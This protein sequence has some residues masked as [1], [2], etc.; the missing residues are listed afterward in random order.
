MPSGTDRPRLQEA[1]VRLARSASL[2]GRPSIAVLDEDLPALEALMGSRTGAH[3]AI[4]GLASQGR[5]HRV[6]R[7]TYVLVDQT[8]GLRVGVLDL[9]AALT[10]KPYLVTGGRALQ[11]HEL[12]DQHFRRVHVLGGAQLRP[13]SWRGDAVR[14]VRTERNLRVA[15]TKTRRTPARIATPER[16]LVDSLSHPRWGVTTSQAVQAL[17]LLLAQDEAVA[18]RLAGEVAG[19]ENHALAR[20]LGFMVTRIAGRQAARVFLPLRGASKAVTPLQ[21]GAALQGPIDSLWQVRE[22]VVFER[23]LEHREIG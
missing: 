22:N 15:A 17:D 18:D 21:P 23:L 20:R 11:F 4:E 8:G 6:R 3:A 10:P 7:G 16:A 12:T 14:Y 2:A 1:F 13:W 9:I 5:L 19:Y